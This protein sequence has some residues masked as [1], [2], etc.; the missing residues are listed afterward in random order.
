MSAIEIKK[1]LLQ[2]N[3]FACKTVDNND[4]N[5]GKNSNN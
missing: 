1:K 5:T 3:Q 4:E 2:T